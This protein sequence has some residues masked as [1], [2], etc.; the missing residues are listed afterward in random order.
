V[1]VKSDGNNHGMDASN[2]VVVRDIAF[3]NV[4]MVVAGKIMVGEALWWQENGG[5]LAEMASQTE[6]WSH[7]S[8]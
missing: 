8:I 1:V 4:V 3:W 2:S 6:K 7:F 5:V